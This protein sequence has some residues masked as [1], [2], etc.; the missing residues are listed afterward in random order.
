MSFDLYKPTP[1]AN[2]DELVYERII[3][4]RYIQ[5]RAKVD[6]GFKDTD[7]LRK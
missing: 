5:S 2:E 4:N 6:F 7:I 1:P 3:G